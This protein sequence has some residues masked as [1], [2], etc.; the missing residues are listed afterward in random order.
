MSRAIRI[1][2]FNE[3]IK[4][5][6][7]KKSDIAKAGVKIWKQQSV[8]DMNA[9]KTKEKY[10]HYNYAIVNYKNEYPGRDI[11]MNILTSA[12]LSAWINIVGEGDEVTANN[13]K[14]C[15]LCGKKDSTEH[16]YESC[17]KIPC[18]EKLLK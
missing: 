1:S 10:K 15:P 16:A 11:I 4:K 5:D 18:H 17:N 9:R 8:D 3:I 12:Q 14:I 6:E 7:Y 13:D 2:T